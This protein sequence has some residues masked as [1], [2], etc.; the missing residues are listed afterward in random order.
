M[1]KTPALACCF[2]ATLA[3]I[4]HAAA[5]GYPAKPIRLIVPLAPGGGNDG[6]ARLVGHRLSEALGQ[7]VIVENRPGA[8]SVLASE[9][10]AKSPPDGYTLYLVSTAFTVAPALYKTLPFD[11]LTDFAPLTRVTIAPGALIVHRS[12]PVHSV[13][14][15]VTLAKAKPGEITF[16]SAGVGAGSHLGGELF[17]MLANVKLVH[18]PYK[19]SAISTAAVMSG[20]VAVA[21]TNPVASMP[22]IK[23]GRLRMIAVTTAQRW[24]LFPDLPTIA[25]SGVPGYE[26]LLWN[27]V[28][29]PA[30]TPMTV[31]TTLHRELTLIMSAASTAEVLAAEGSR[32]YIEPRHVFAA[33]LEREIIK[34][35]QVVQRARIN[36]N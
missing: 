27:G 8:G 29:A 1:Q 3:L 23:S 12:L 31:L 7:Q 17:N 19:G 36:A 32:P 5:Q 30:A 16:G 14:D 25:E 28:S 6:A 10:V 4:A 26:L 21:F 33:F 20:E 34:W 11:P 13:R 22:H 15:L 18:V 35:K 24:P 9:V 2:I